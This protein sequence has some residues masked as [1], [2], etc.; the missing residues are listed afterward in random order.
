MIIREIVDSISGLFFKM[1]N[2]NLKNGYFQLF[3]SMCLEY[4]RGYMDYVNKY[5]TCIFN[6]RFGLSLNQTD[7]RSTHCGKIIESAIVVSLRKNALKIN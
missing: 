4:M 1:E 2:Y 5:T 6:G 7:N 3:S